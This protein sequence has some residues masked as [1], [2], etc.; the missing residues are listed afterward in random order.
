MDNY[1]YTFKYNEGDKTVSYTFRADITIDEVMENLYYFL[2][3]CGWDDDILSTNM[4]IDKI[5]NSDIM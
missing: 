1:T 4:D 2:K 3:A 5:K